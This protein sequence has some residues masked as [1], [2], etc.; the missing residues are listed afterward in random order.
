MPVPIHKRHMISFSHISNEH[1]RCQAVNPVFFPGTNAHQLPL[2]S[3][4]SNRNNYVFPEQEPASGSK[5][6]L[7]ESSQS[8]LFIH[9]N[10]WMTA[11]EKPGRSG[12]AEILTI[13][14]WLIHEELRTGR[15][16]V[17]PR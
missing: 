2:S 3:R 15:E 1:D 17:Q 14:G 4:Q 6:W 10:D 11:I 13:R 5:Q 12:P 7:G 16:K 8:A 9:T